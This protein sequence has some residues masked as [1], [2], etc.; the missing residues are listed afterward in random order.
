MTTTAHLATGET[1]TATATTRLSASG[2][3][4]H[5][6]V[7]VNGLATVD[8]TWHAP[9]PRTVRLFG[10]VLRSARRRPRGHG[11]GLRPP[12]R[13]RKRR[14]RS[15]ATRPRADGWLTVDLGSAQR[16]A[17]VTVVWEAA[18]GRRYRIETS[19]DGVVSA[20]TQTYPRPAVSTDEGWLDV[21][22]RAGFVVTGSPHPITVTGDQILLS[23]GA[24]APL[25][26]QCRP[27]P[28]SLASVAKAPGPTSSA[29]AVRPSVVDGHLVL[30]NLSGSGAH[31]TVAL[32]A[33]GGR[34]TALP[35]RPGD[36]EGRQ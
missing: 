26:V 29:R 2:L 14:T 7:T 36:H 32:P 19:Q 6:T 9:P 13:A 28:R 1:I 22:G 30:L 23:D 3:D 16:F 34:R 31:G 4:V 18:A 21:D 24:A 35:G 20:A 15:T 17:R 25:Q 12:R 10:L 33:A 5:G 11:V 8:R 27:D